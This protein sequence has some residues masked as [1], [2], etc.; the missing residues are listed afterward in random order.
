MTQ[1]VD[2]EQFETGLSGCVIRMRPRPSD[3]H[4]FFADATVAALVADAMA[5]TKPVHLSGLSGTGKT[6]FLGSLLEV[7]ENFDLLCAALDAPR[8]P[9]LRMHRIPVGV[10]ETPNEMFY[11]PRV[12]NFTSVEEPQPV[13]RALM[14][15]EED[16]AA[17][18]VVWLEELGRG[19]TPAVQSS[20]LGLVGEQV[21][22]EPRG[23][24]FELPNVAFVCDSNY[25]ANTAGQFVLYDLDQAVARRW[26]R[27]ITMVPLAL[28]HEGAVLKEIM[29]EATDTQVRQVVALA[30]G[31]RRKQSEGAL[32]SIVPPTI[33]AELE[34]LRGMCRGLADV[35]TN[36]FTTLLGH[37][38]PE[39]DT[40]EAETV[41]AE[42]FGVQVKTTT[43]AGEAVGIL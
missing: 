4:P 22:H 17:L 14:A 9:Q 5:H 2:I 15:A 26:L 35:R 41:Y 11:L 21:I 32:R 16:A 20:L 33:D 25:A 42:A 6:H 10:Y 23:R 1:I 12:E 29:P 28:E 27:R 3:A 8:W 30:V 7:G 40:D 43:P 37:C 19:I 36:V 39:R 24:V 18:H 31:I 13:L 38:D 34:C